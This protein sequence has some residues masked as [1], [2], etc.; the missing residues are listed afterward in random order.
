MNFSR[1]T[2]VAASSLAALA[3]LALAGCSKPA[4]APAS[5]A[6]G[7]AATASAPAKGVSAP[8]VSI[9]TVK[10]KKRD[11]AVN[12]KATG[13]VVPLTVVDVKAQVT[14]TVRQVHFKEGQFVKAGQL[15]FTLDARTEVANLTKSQAQLAKDRVSL[16]DAKRQLE[17]ARQLLAQNFVSQVAVDTAQM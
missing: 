4:D 9:T 12:L 11:L 14:S 10:A 2:F 6:S 1:H 16:A 3:V 17:R 8:P 13:T 5:A 15:L 7:A